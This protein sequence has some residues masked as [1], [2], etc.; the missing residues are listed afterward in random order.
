LF[1]R[2]G[3]PAY[4]PID[5]MADKPGRAGLYGIQLEDKLNFEIYCRLN[6][7]TVLRPMV[8]SQGER[9]GNLRVWSVADI[10]RFHEQFKWRD[11]SAADHEQVATFF[12]D[13]RHWQR[14]LDYVRDPDVMHVH[15]NVETSVHPNVLRAYAL[16][17]LARR[18]FTVKHS[19]HSIFNGGG[20]DSGKIIFLGLNPPRTYDIAYYH[21]P[22]V[23]L[24][25]NTQ[26][27][28]MV[29]GA[30]TGNEY[31]VVRVTTLQEELAKHSLIR[32]SDE[33]IASVL[34]TVCS[35][36]QRSAYSW[37]IVPAGTVNEPQ[38]GW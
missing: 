13:S 17:D 27:T 22:D 3:W 25:V 10:R 5:I 2:L 16:D 4:R 38:V 23:L 7:Q 6:Q 8:A 28:R 12:R 29:G 14:T 37:R 11:L 34:S 24:Q 26:E 30:G 20:Y 32:L 9:G 21:N 1:S 31:Y 35:F 19:I 36:Y 33:E 18:G 15:C